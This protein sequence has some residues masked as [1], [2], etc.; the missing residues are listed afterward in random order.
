MGGDFTQA[1]DAPANGGA[2][3]TR[4]RVAAISEATGALLAWNPN[5]NNSV[6]ALAVSG[7]TVYAGG[8]FTTIGGQARSSIA[9]LDAA[10]GLATAW[11][12]T[13]IGGVTALAVSGTT[14]YAGGVFTNIGG[15]ARNRIAALDAGTGLATAWNPNANSDV[16]ALAVSGTTVYAGGLFST[17][18]GA[19]RNRI[20]ALDA[21]TGLATAWNPNASSTVHALAVSGTTVYVGGNFG[22]IGGQARNCIAALDAGTGLATAWN[23]NANSTVFALAVSGTTVYTGGGFSAIGG[24]TRNFIAALDAGTGLATAWNP[25]ANNHAGCFAVNGTTVYVGG[26]WTTATG[27]TTIGGAARQGFAAFGPAV[28]PF[29]GITSF[30]PTSGG[31][32]TTVVI[33]GSGFTGATAVSVGGIPAASFTVNSNTQITAVLGSGSAGSGGQQLVL[34]TAPGGVFSL[35]GFSLGTAGASSGSGSAPSGGTAQSAVI[36]GLSPGN[37]GFGTPI[38]LSGSGFTG[39]TGLLIGGIAV[40]NFVVVNDNTITAI[41]GGVPVSDRV[42]LTGGAGASLDMSGLGVTYTRL[43]PPVIAAI[44]PTSLVASGDDAVLELS[45]YYF[46]TGARVLVSERG[47]NGTLSDALPLGVQSVNATQ[48]VISFAGIFR[49]PGEKV[50][51]LLNP[52]GQSS[53]VALTVITGAA[54]RLVGADNQ[55]VVFSTT[56]SGRAFSVRLSGANIFRTVRAFL[57][58]LPAQ[59]TVPSSTEA[60]VEVPASVNDIGGLNLVLRLQNSDG[61]STTATLRIERRPPPTITGVTLQSGGRLVVRGVNFLAGIRSALGNSAL[62]LV[63]QDGDTQFTA[64][65]PPSFRLTANSPTVSLTVQNSDGRSHGVLLPRSM[66]EAEMSASSV[67]VVNTE[68]TWEN[69]ASAL[70]IAEVVAGKQLQSGSQELGVFP[71]PMEGELRIGGAGVRTVRVYDMRGGAVLEERTTSGVVNVSALGAGAYMVVVEAAD[72]RVVRQR[73]VKR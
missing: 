18:G 56:A 43:I 52:D 71:N 22:T 26:F 33:T 20:A 46:L 65:I 48:A 10:T 51:T 9:A 11:N 38:T 59:V 32:G 57:G 15:Q 49:S 50:I 42:V 23:P 61:S 14:V 25:N 58:D 35:G 31:V 28:A 34:V 1:T 64:Q 5:A 45:G 68:R 53:R 73:V 27:F 69:T 7:T 54:V 4:N 30:T 17:I 67:S 16:R 63:S 2:T 41:V 62:T 40:T 12:P 70:E 37:I 66:F 60:I 47:A 6:I 36:G 29:Q 21:G 44:S 13:S 55:P 19:G 39:A 72:G 24:Q 3:V 8:G